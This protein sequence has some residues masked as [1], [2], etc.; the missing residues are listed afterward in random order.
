VDHTPTGVSNNGAFRIT[1]VIPLIPGKFIPNSIRIEFLRDMAV[2]EVHTLWKTKYTIKGAQ[3][4]IIKLLI[5]IKR[6]VA[7]LPS[8]AARDFNVQCA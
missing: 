8:R 1:I 7:L 4:E 5:K 2:Q 6:N 3:I